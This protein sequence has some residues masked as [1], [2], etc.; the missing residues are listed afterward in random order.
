MEAL[1]SKF[2][3]YLQI[4]K[5]ASD[6][7]QRN[8]LSDLRQFKEFLQAKEG[9]SQ[10]NVSHI[11]LIDVKMIRS[12]LAYLFRKG[13]SSSSMARKL[14][15]LR[16]FFKFLHREG[17]VSTNWAKLVLTPKQIRKLPSYMTVDEAFRLVESP[18]ADTF[19]EL[20]D[21]AILETFYS[22]G[23]RI[24]EL[25]SL[26]LKN[27]DFRLGILHVMGKG[28]KERIAPLGEKALEA[29]KKYLTARSSLMEKESVIKSQEATFLSQKGQRLSVRRTRDLVYKYAKLVELNKHISPHALRH[30]CATHLLEAGAD[31]RFI[32]E[33]L[34][35]ASLSTTQRYT[36]ISIDRLLA[37]Y[38]RAHPRAKAGKSS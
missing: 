22:S 6:H 14:A 32:Q 11:Q 38:D 5:N 3:R 17:V 20:R 7:T 4:E 34:G 37:V 21:K 18:R 16:T 35:H 1:L 28:G 33:L 2:E 12:F 31:L 10:I 30:S 9:V 26:N 13:N 27:I 19:A 15:S 8:Y 23:I 36:H 25:V 29:L 24:S